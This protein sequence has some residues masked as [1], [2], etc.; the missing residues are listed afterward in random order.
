MRRLVAILVAAVA[1]TGTGSAGE[2]SPPKHTAPE[3]V[4]P[5]D[6]S[7]LLKEH[8]LGPTQFPLRDQCAMNLIEL[9]KYARTYALAKNGKLPRRLEDAALHHAA[10]MYEHATC[11]ASKSPYVYVDV[12]PDGRTVQDGPEDFLAFDAEPAHQG[13]RCVL[14]ANGDVSYLAEEEFQRRWAEQQEKWSARG[15]TLEQVPVRAE[16]PSVWG[17]MHFR[18]ALAI[19]L[20]IGIVVVLHILYSRSRKPHEGPGSEDRTSNIEHPTSNAERRTPDA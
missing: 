12:V 19:A 17:S 13:G 10:S 8:Q 6:V 5:P 9:G 3:I 11:P 14:L 18:I 7:Q 2:T 4:P 16:R 15:Q 20:A 1:L